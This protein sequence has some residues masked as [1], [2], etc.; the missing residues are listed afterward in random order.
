MFN[1]PQ[2]SPPRRVV[3]GKCR[4]RVQR[5]PQRGLRPYG[6]FPYFLIL[7]ISFCYFPAN[8]YAQVYL[9]EEKVTNEQIYRKLI[10]FEAKTEERF[11]A[12]D[13]RFEMM[14]N[15]ISI[16]FNS[17][18]QRI[19]DLFTFLWI[20]TGIFAAISGVTISLAFWDR[21]TIV[22]TSVKKSFDKVESEGTSK[23]LLDALREIAKEDQK[24]A[25]ILKNFNLL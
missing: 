25:T 11:K 3:A 6:A 4:R 14:E 1:P 9:E 12:I 2:D 19:S 22:E 5:T 24:V 17:V 23:K 21:K 8:L 7:L 15:S 20:L 18:E 10:T 16:R 13:Q